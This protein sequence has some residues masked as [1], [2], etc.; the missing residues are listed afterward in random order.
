[1]DILQMI[2]MVSM[3]NWHYEEVYLMTT[4]YYWKDIDRI[5]KELMEGVPA[6]D[7]N[8]DAIYSQIDNIFKSF[9]Q[10]KTIHQKS[11]QISFEKN[12]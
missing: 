4:Q 12:F 1:M 10:K 7:H 8:H 5:Q 6:L 11:F 2:L 3:I 9:N